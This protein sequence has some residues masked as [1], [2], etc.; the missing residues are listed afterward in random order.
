MTKK[1]VYLAGGW[2]T[3]EQEEEHTRIYELI[4]DEYDVFNP[5]LASL[6]K[7]GATQD[8]MT[9]TLLGNLEAIQNADIVLVI[10][11][12]K[13]MGTIWEAGYAYAN[14][15][16][17]IYYAETL[18]N[19]PFNLMLAKTG[20]VALNMIQLLYELSNEDNYKFEEVKHQYVGEIE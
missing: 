11:D 9:Q 15:K 14:K 18:G 20:V 10:T 5:K 6:V 4:K 3:P 19:R 16:P 17:I 7:P 12:R 13:D 1:K 8:S 2:F